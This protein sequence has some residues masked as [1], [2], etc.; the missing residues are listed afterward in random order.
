MHYSILV[1]WGGVGGV[2]CSKLRKKNSYKKIILPFRIDQN[3]AVH[4]PQD[5]HD[6]ALTAMFDISVCRY[7]DAEAVM[8]AVGATAFVSLS[9]S[10]F[11]MQSKV[12]S[13]TH[14]ELSLQCSQK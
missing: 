14:S 10:L 11:A 3:P 12:R 1:Q 9:L 4:P 7:F 2:Q 8:W 13:V 5:R 6:S